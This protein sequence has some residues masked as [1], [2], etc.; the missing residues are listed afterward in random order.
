M[1]TDQQDKYSESLKQ[2]K[3]IIDSF[4]KSGLAF[5]ASMAQVN[6]PGDPDVIEGFIEIIGNTVDQKIDPELSSD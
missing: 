1:E 3:E 5:L 6:N 4:M 2:R